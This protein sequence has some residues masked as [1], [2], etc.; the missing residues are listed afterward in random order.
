MELIALVRNCP[1]LYDKSRKDFKDF[2]KKDAT[3]KAIAAVMH[4]SITDCQ[5][6]WKCL[7]EQYGRIKRAMSANTLNTT[8]PDVAKMIQ[9]E[10]IDDMKFLDPHI[11]PRR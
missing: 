8:D 11:R 10:F 5:N 2:D 1:Y 4:C 9:W 7:R 6:R 3:W